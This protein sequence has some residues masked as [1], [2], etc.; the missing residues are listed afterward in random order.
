MHSTISPQLLHL[1]DS[2]LPTGGYAYSN[3]LES[4]AK[5]GLI[6][7]LDEFRDY[8]E[9]FLLQLSDCELPFIG[10][11]FAA[12]TPIPDQ[13]LLPIV[14]A[15]DALTWLPLTRRWS[16]TTARTWLNLFERLYPDVR[17]DDLRGWFGRHHIEPQFTIVYALTMR[18]AGYSSTDARTL[19]RYM[20]VRDQIT[21]AIRLGL[22]GPADAHAM[23]HDFCADSATEPPGDFTEA[24]RSS[25]VLELAQ[26]AHQRVYAKLFQN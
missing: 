14:E 8:V 13:S 24:F 2:A 5:L 23:L 6:R 3:G 10:A 20:S 26:A 17:A 4:A 21:A 15:Y 11:C 12:P 1:A 18:L 22:L 7:T 9:S 19:L 16:T 25:P